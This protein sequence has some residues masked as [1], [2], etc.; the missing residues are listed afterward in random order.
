MLPQA[1]ENVFCFDWFDKIISYEMSGNTWSF[2]SNVPWS[3]LSKI[4]LRKHS[5]LSILI[6]QL[7]LYIAE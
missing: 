7:F 2:V 5:T 6:L 1:Y 4:K 3:V